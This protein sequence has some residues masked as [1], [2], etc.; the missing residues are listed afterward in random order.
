[1][2]WLPMNTSDG[3]TCKMQVIGTDNFPLKLA[4]PVLEE[5]YLGTVK[6]EP[7]SNYYKSRRRPPVSG[8]F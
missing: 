7:W 1:M 6:T 2:P 3:Y 8:Y 5:N 4:W